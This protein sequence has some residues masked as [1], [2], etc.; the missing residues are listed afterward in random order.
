MD[1]T[2]GRER[3]VADDLL[4]TCRCLDSSFE[5]DAVRCEN[6]ES[7]FDPVT[8]TYRREATYFRF[9]TKNVITER[10]SMTQFC[11]FNIKAGDIFIGYIE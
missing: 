9:D 11:G 4:T 7:G 6:D 3:A 5:M 1:E 2:K 8:T 10:E